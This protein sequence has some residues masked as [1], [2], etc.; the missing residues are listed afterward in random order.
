MW[1]IHTLNYSV[2][3]LM[4]TFRSPVTDS[5][6]EDSAESSTDEEEEAVTNPEER[7]RYS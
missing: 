2:I 4:C 1:T 5:D 6:E 3:D 7:E